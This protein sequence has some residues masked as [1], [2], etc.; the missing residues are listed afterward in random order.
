[1]LLHGRGP[2]GKGGSDYFFIPT[3][4]ARDNAIRTL[5]VHEAHFV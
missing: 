1:L 4:S 5:V 3:N 2:A